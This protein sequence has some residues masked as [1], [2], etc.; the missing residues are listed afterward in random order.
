MSL[1]ADLSK[2]AW[3]AKTWGML[4]SAEKSDFLTIAGKRKDHPETDVN[5][6][7]VELRGN[8]K[9]PGVRRQGRT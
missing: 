9:H 3:W 6:G 4:F 1:S 5:R 7:K 2:A 8:T